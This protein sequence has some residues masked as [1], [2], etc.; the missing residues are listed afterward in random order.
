MSLNSGERQ[1]A[2]TVDGIRADHVERYRWAAAQLPRG[3]YVVDVGC[4]IGYGARILADAGH[5]VLALDVDAETIRYAREYYAHENIEFRLASA[6]DAGSLAG[7]LIER[8]PDAAVCF[9]MIEHVAEPLPMLRQLRAYVGTLLASVPNETVFPWAGYAFHYRHYTKD[10]FRRLLADAGFQANVWLGQEGPESPVAVGVNGRTL[11]AVAVAD[12]GSG[13]PTGFSVAPDGIA[14]WTPVAGDDV[15]APEHVAILGLG[16]SVR[17]FLEVTK[18]MGGRRAFCDEVWGIN[19]LGD[20]FACDRIFHMDDVRVQEI[21]SAARPDSNIAHMLRWLKTYPGPV[22]TSRA[23]SDYPGLVEFPLEAVLNEFPDAYFNSTAAY[24]I[25]YALHLGVKKISVFGFDFTYPDAHDAEKGRACV[26]FWLGLASAHGVQI[27]LPRTTSL[28][29][30][31]YQQDK[32]FYGYDTLDLDINRGAD[33]I[34]VTRTERVQLPTAEE[35]EREYD[36]A[37]FP[38]Q[39]LADI[40]G[41]NGG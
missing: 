32:R 3:S 18:R 5:R 27:A 39:R 23:H 17:Q 22:V 37:A 36:H 34:T 20:V 4:G 13:A 30:A 8:A 24:A 29:D 14:K 16:P 38:R 11:L 6:T 31:M 19:A 15:R 2:P 28:M 40:E 1:V 12:E 9:E 25:A 26:E 7:I 35:I 33:G 41:A 21:R 10:D